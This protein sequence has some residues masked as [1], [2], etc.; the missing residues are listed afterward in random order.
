MICQ[1]SSKPGS[2]WLIFFVFSW[3]LFENDK[4]SANH[5]FHFLD[6]LTDVQQILCQFNLTVRNLIKFLVQH[7][8][9]VVMRTEG[10]LYFEFKAFQVEFK[11][12]FCLL[13]FGFE[14]WLKTV[15]F[16]FGDWQL[17]VRFQWVPFE[18]WGF[19]CRFPPWLHWCLRRTRHG[20][21]ERVRRF[22]L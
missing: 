2:D 12:S 10:P 21:C 7:L 5:L 17:W 15:L 3:L 6:F 22:V 19:R 4:N 11:V 16:V 1:K 13:Y 8:D 18:W 14:D 9:H 20:N